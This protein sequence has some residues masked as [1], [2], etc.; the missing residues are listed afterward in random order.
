MQFP[1]ISVKFGI[2]SYG[3]LIIL[4]VLPL[5]MV[6]PYWLQVSYYSLLAL[7][8]GFALTYTNTPIGVM[9]QK[10]AVTIININYL[11]IRQEFTPNH[12]LGRVAGT[13]STL[14]KLAMPIGFLLGG[15]WVEWFQVQTLFM[16]TACII[17]AIFVSLM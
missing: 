17:L 15:L 2:I 11:A 16:M 3:L 5:M 10:M 8:I 4:M 6:F 1:L 12:L 13:S 7:S 9:M 14:M